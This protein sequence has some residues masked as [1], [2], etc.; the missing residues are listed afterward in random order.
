MATKTPTREPARKRK[1]T[2]KRVK[3]F[4]TERAVSGA[5]QAVSSGSVALPREAKVIG[6]AAGVLLNRI[7]AGGPLNE[8]ETLWHAVQ[9]V[10]KEALAEWV[11]SPVPSLGGQTPYALLQTAKG[12]DQV[13]RVLGQIEHGIY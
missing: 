6:S 11:N 8:V 7:D 13:N 12:R 5:H 4:G 10:G 3:L 2:S 9:V 1:P